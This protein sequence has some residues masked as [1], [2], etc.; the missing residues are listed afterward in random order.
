M[1]R[2]QSSSDAAMVSKGL[3]SSEGEERP[4]EPPGTCMVKP[5]CGWGGSGVL[6]PFSRSSGQLRP[7][8]RIGSTELRRGD[9]APLTFAVSLVSH[10]REWSGSSF[11][12]LTFMRLCTSHFMLRSRIDTLRVHFVAI[13]SSY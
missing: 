10:L 6:S 5:P 1:G 11:S 4:A 8:G 13:K 7:L 9:S 12:E 2:V 3:L